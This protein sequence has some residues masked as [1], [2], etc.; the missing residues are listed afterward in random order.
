VS[1]TGGTE[2]MSS[3]PYLVKNSRFGTALGTSYHFEDYIQ[4]Q[5]PDSYTGTTLEKIA[6]NIAKKYQVSRKEVDEIALMSH[7]R[8][9]TGK[10]IINNLI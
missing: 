2:I 1:L 7:S 10:C 4:K 8:W 9:T 6:E 3:L 5:F